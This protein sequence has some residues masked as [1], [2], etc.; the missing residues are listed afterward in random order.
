MNTVEFEQMRGGRRPS[1]DF[2]NVHHLDI[3]AIPRG[4]ESKAAHS[5]KSIYSN[6]S[7]LLVLFLSGGF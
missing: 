2:V 4:A 1:L 5:P 3:P 6:A 7:H